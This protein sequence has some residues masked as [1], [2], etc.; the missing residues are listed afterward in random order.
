VLHRRGENI[1]L[2]GK[3]KPECSELVEMLKAVKPEDFNSGEMSYG[4]LF[5]EIFSDVARY[6]TTTKS[7]N[8]YNGKVWTTDT[9]SMVVLGY[10]KEL[11]DALLIYGAWLP[12]GKIKDSFVEFIA[13][14]TNLQARERMVKDARSEHFFSKNDLD[15]D[16]LTFNC[17]NGT[18]DLKTFSFREHASDDLLSKISNV[19]YDPD[20]RSERW[21]SFIDEVLEGDIEKMSYFQKLLGYSLT[22]STVIEQCFILYGPKTRN[23]KS[24]TLETYAYMLG[25][26]DGYAVTISPETLAIKVNNNSRNHSSDVARLRGTRFVNAAEFP[27]RMPLDNALIKNWTGGDRISAREIYEKQSEF[28][29]MFKLF[30]NTNHLPLITDK[31]LFT[32]KRIN[33]IEFNRHFSENEQDLTL[34]ATLREPENLTGIFNWCIEG[35]IKCRNEGLEP[36]QVII[37]ANT[38]YY[39]SSD[40]IQQFLDDCLVKSDKNSKVSLVYQLYEQW[41]DE[42]GLCALS[43]SNFIDEMKFKGIYASAGRVDGENYKNIL[44]NHVPKAS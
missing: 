44:R 41:C 17:L 31:T 36:P 35:L 1:K 10:A 6:N 32:S 27:Q 2:D 13:R 22:G 21:I 30:L 24:T 3:Y 29:P 19:N 43:K 4:R 38:E 16:P 14:Y 9:E 25:N 20:I 34:K 15:K 5:A 39:N 8:T 37:D 7:W 42:C 23:G 12:D 11:C 26:I 18:L 28:Q 33:V 40:K